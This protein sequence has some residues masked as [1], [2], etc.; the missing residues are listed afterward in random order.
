MAK[1]MPEQS[2]VDPATGKPEWAMSRRERRRLQRAQLGLPPPRRKWPWVALVLLIALGL[3]AWTQRD[4]IEAQ[5]AAAPAEEPVVEE[6]AAPQ[7]TQI[8]RGEWTTVEP[9][10]LRRTI[11]VIGTLQPSRRAELSAETAGQVEAVLARSGDAVEEG[12]LLVQVDVEGLEIDLNLARSNAEATRSELGLAEGQLERQQ[13]LAERGVAATAALD[14]AQTGVQRLRATLAAQED[15]I[16]AAERALRGAAVRAPFDGVIAERT[17]EAG[18]VVAPG[19]PLLT[20]VDLRRM[21]MRAQSPIAA[22]AVLAPGQV[23]ELRVDGVAGRSFEGVVDRVAPVADEGTRA[24]TV[25]ALIEN[26]DGRLLG[27]MFATGEVVTAEAVDALA[28]PQEAVRT[29]DGDHLLVIE[30]GTIAR[31]NVMI[32]E[33]WGGLVEV[34]GLEPGDQVVTA[35][36][37]GL[38]P[39]ETVELV[40]F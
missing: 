8:N 28:V 12:A 39:G 16:S 34:E 38:E 9:Q 11:K 30:D 10:T 37:E 32:G 20:I 23:V 13:A 15:Q 26:E 29:E 5:L 4:L 17:V 27:G 33:T 7:L 22:G 31:R 19:T 40:E 25:Y 36:L 21:E 2:A 18:N 3:G 1:D 6:P 35:P 14:E 24:L